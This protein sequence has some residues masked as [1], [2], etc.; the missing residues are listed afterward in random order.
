MPALA[1]DFW[2][3]LTNPDSHISRLDVDVLVKE[4]T[5]LEWYV[6]Q[7]QTGVMMMV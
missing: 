2:V 7:A 1:N 3:E 6:Q 4:R 5:L